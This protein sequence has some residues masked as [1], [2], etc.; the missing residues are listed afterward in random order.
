MTGYL[1][2]VAR[3]SPSRHTIKRTGESLE[4]ARTLWG[5]NTPLQAL[6]MEHLEQLWTWL[7]DASTGRFGKQRSLD[8]VAKHLTT[9][10]TFWEWAEKKYGDECP[11]P[12]RIELPRDP[13]K[14]P[15]APTWAQ[16][17]AMIAEL[18]V[19]WHRRVAT[20]A[21]FTGARSAELLA[22]DWSDVDLGQARILWQPAITKGGY[23][24]RGLPMPPA[25]V[26]ELAGW[27]K[28]EGQ[29]V[30]A[31]RGAE[32]HMR[33]DF[34]RAWKRAGIPERAW[35]GQPTHAFR[36]AVETELRARGVSSEVINVYLG[37]KDTSVGA[38]HYADAW[39]S[40]GPVVEA[41]KLIAPIAKTARELEV[42]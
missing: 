23:G 16:C 27:G 34:A 12:R 14:L 37:H 40:F 5:A 30:Q 7:R 15:R 29:V 22:L 31:P 18:S 38:K 42:V 13:P 36:K 1:G 32:G 28:R 26:E 20:L 10:H 3:V 6:T 33:D 19:E 2:H 4:Y 39:W 9:L 11:R 8:T 24:G 17:D 21:R 25:L 41:V 35:K